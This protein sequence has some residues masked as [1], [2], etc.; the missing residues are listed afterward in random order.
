M[1]VIVSSLDEN[2]WLCYDGLFD[3]YWYAPAHSFKTKLFKEYPKDYLKK[4]PID[5]DVKVMKI[6]LQDVS[7]E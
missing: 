3:E 4:I 1:Y 5:F 6:V 7:G 2:Q